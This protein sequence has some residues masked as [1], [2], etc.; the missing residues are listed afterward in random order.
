[1]KKLL[2]ALCLIFALQPVTA[3]AD[4][5]FKF[6]PSPKYQKYFERNE[7][8]SIGNFQKI[9]SDSTEETVQFV[10][11]KTGDLLTIRDVANVSND[12]Y[13]CSVAFKGVIAD[14]KGS[15]LYHAKSDEKEQI[16]VSP[17]MGYVVVI[18]QKCFDKP[19][20]SLMVESKPETYCNFINHCFGNVGL[21]TYRP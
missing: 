16:I 12:I 15:M 9:V 5:D 14:G 10:V 7:F 2:F 21:K 1:M 8:D 6:Y 20:P 18:F 13:S 4:F 11:E 3:Q 19:A 17:G